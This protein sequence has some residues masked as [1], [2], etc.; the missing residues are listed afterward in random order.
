M[1]YDRLYARIVVLASAM[2]LFAAGGHAQSTWEQ[3]EA[4]REA[5]E[6][7]PDMLQA[8]AIRPGAVVADV[9]AGGGFLTARLSRA[10]GPDGRVFA[11]DVSPRAI[12]RLRSR[13]KQDGL[14]NVEVVKGEADNPHLPEAVLDAAVIVNAYHEMDEHVAM[15]RHLRSALKPGGRLVIVEPL[16]EAFRRAS[17]A[18]Q[19][20]RHEIAPGIV[21]QELREAGFR[22]VRLEDPFT[23]RG[24]DTMWLLAAVPDPIAI[25]GAMCPLPARKPTPPAAAGGGDDPV[26][27]PELRIAMERFKMLRQQDAVVVVDVRTEGEYKEG[28]VPGAIWIS[29]R[30]IGEHAATL[31]ATGQ[32]VITYCS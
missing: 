5:R 14:A 13:V 11:V 18:E 6:R 23:T 22:I 30:T 1:A 12:E 3:E 32:P 31:K 15:L 24:Q 9:G 20:R 28:H 10:V 2:A 17:R 4:H 7:V 29:L 21:D 26:A 27:N 8:M 25:D 19:T 16:S